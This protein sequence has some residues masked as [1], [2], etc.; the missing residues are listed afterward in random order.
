MTLPI[1]QLR[2]GKFL[3]LVNKRNK[4]RGNA[5]GISNA[6]LTQ[7]GIPFDTNRHYVIDDFQQIT[8]S[9]TNGPK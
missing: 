4:G 5:R 7:Q 2:Y 6:F 1:K 9:D 3:I 8:K